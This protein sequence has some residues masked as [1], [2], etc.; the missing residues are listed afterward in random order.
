MDREKIALDAQDKKNVTQAL[1][2]AL[3]NEVELSPLSWVSS[4]LGFQSLPG[5]FLPTPS[6]ATLFRMLSGKS[7]LQ[8]QFTKVIERALSLPPNLL[9]RAHADLS[10]WALEKKIASE[11]CREDETFIHD[12]KEQARKSLDEARNPKGSLFNY[13]SPILDWL[14]KYLSEISSHIRVISYQPGSFRCYLADS[15]STLRQ[16][17]SQVWERKSASEFEEH[18]GV[19]FELAGEIEISGL[20]IDPFSTD[21]IILSRIQIDAVIT[22]DTLQLNE[23]GLVFQAEILKQLWREYPG[24]LMKGIVGRAAEGGWIDKENGILNEGE[25]GVRDGMGSWSG[26]EYR[27]ANFEA[28]NK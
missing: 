7:A 10:A 20:A 5:V 9:R 14:N 16:K 2:G 26:A 23:F 19:H 24:A 11:F 8:M 15:D 13:F 25:F 21:K 28:E 22:P 18:F 1:L 17:S 12:L 3:I 27:L 4:V 6:R